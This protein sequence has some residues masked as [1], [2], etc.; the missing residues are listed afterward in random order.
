M[1][2]MWRNLFV[3]LRGATTPTHA[4]GQTAPSL[5][6]YAGFALLLLLAVLFPLP[7]LVLDGLLVAGFVF[8]AYWFVV[9]MRADGPLSV[10]KLPTVL[11]L[12]LFA[13]LCLSVALAKKGLQT[14]QVGA[15]PGALLSLF[16]EADL[17]AGGLL[18]F[19]LVAAEYV[20]LARG[21]ERVAEVAARFALDAMPGRQAAIEADVRQGALGVVEAQAARQ[22]LTR[23]AELYGALDGVVRLLRGDVLLQVLFAAGLGLLQLLQLSATDLA[24][25]ETAEQAARMVIAVGLSTQFP[26]VLLAIGTVLVL[27]RRPHERASDQTEAL[28]IVF[29]DPDAR[30]L[31]A[32]TAQ[33]A[34]QQLGLHFLQHRVETESSSQ[35]ESQT[36]RQTETQT[37][38]PSQT[39]RLLRV[40]CHGETVAERMVLPDEKPEAVL[41]AML[42]SSSHQL[43]SLDGLRAA[44]SALSKDQPAL[45][46][47]VVPK[48]LPLGKLLF[49]LRRLLSARVWPLPLSAVLETLATLPELEA[50]AEL[51]VEQ[52]RSGLGFHLLRNHLAVHNLGP[53]SEGLPVLVLS[54]DLENVLRESRT[55]QPHARFSLEPDLRKDILD[56]VRIAKQ[57]TPDALLV[58]HKALRRPVQDLL[59]VVPEALPVLAF[60]ELPPQLPLRIKNR[61]G[62]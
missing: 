19:A 5:S 1:V 43:L 26:I 10:P 8:S 56:S 61:I 33:V 11:L 32:Q 12:S 57:R 36:E 58:C 13:R 48:R 35:T 49:V 53:G 14:G 52:V 25:G 21:G 2:S 50:D 7:S 39:Q 31:L 54:E 46:L 62:P 38:K 47:E 37:P 55:D 16:G 29:S 9:S 42:L 59:A 20:L 44:L 27:L 4:Q 30:P 23:E 60:S 18:F 40:L 51:L 45:V 6:L 34:L 22:A 3:F 17:A 24:A 28:V 41:L 15:V